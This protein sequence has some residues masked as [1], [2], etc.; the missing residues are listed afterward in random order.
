LAFA[1]WAAVLGAD[2][3]PAFAA[4]AP[5]VSVRIEGATRTVWTGAVTAGTYTLVDSNG[6]SHTLSRKALCTVEA[7]ARV[8][9]FSYV[10]KWFSFGGFIDAMGPDASDPN[11]PYPGWMYRVNGMSPS[12]GADQHTVKNGDSVLWYYGAWDASPTVAVTPAMVA[13]GTT[14][15]VLAQ[16]LDPVGVASPL[17]D[18]TVHVGSRVATSDAAGIVR[19]LMADVGT[20]G[21]RVEKAGYIRS[22]VRQVKVGRTCTFAGF[23]A[24]RSRVRRLGAF[25]LTGRLMSRGKGLSQR[26]FQIQRKYPSGPWTLERTA[27]TGWLGK[28]RVVIYPSKTAAYRAVWGGDASTLAATSKS[29]TV[30]VGS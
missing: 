20:F 26:F 25:V 16:Q 21:V 22:A 19:M 4:P 3:L 1:F 2:A 9:G 5:R 12:D 7:A 13:V 30:K 15:T 28:F 8:V 18:A 29:K 6:D 24:S 27:R 10:L 14:L 17:P 23:T 11:P